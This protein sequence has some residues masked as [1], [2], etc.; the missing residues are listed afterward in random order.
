VQDKF[1]IFFYAAAIILWILYKIREQKKSGM[2]ERRTPSTPAKPV[3]PVAREVAK[4][5]MVISRKQIKKVQPVRKEESSA[6][7]KTT[8]V[9]R[10]DS[11]FFKKVIEEDFINQQML[12]EKN[13][14]EE[15]ILP[16]IR[17]AIIGSVILT[18]PVW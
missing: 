8:V 11:S 9:D 13:K 14:D 5:P 7:E 15:I 2:W 17:M 1:K 3:K 16:D 12:A 10:H 6:T 4:A 18:R